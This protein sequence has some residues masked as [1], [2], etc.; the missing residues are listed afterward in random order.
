MAGEMD[1]PVPVKDSEK[2]FE[3]GDSGSGTAEQ[4]R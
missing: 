3:D 2:G 4:I 1:V